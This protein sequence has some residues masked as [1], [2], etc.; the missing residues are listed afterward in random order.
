MYQNEI[1]STEKSAKIHLVLYE[2]GDYQ[3][4]NPESCRDE[5]AKAGPESE[6]HIEFTKAS[7]PSELFS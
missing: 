1:H 4:A 6:I 2:C 7:T 3:N 5:I